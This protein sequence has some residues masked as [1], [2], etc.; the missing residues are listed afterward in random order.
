MNTTNNKTVNANT[1]T[2][3]S[4]QKGS[5]CDP[6]D[7]GGLFFVI[8]ALSREGEP[9]NAMVFVTDAQLEKL[10]EAHAMWR[11]LESRAVELRAIE[12]AALSMN[13]W[14]AAG[15]VK[16]LVGKGVN[17]SPSLALLKDEGRLQSNGRATKAA[18]Y[19]VASPKIIE[20]VDWTG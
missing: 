12:T 7:P 11:D 18:R 14:F 8:Q 19:R 20:R 13:G 17:V 16:A 2:A 10:D 15:D 4:D 6:E 1:K 3:L 9:C 5:R